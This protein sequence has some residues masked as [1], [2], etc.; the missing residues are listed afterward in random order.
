[1]APPSRKKPVAAVTHDWSHMSALELG[2]LFED[3]VADPRDVT[4]VFLAHAEENDPDHRIYVRLTKERARAEAAA[5]A[6]RA[7]RGLRRGPLDGV[8]LSWKDNFDMAGEPTAAGSLPLKDR[9]PTHDAEVLTRLTQAGLVA[10][11]KTNMTELAFSG[12]GINPNFGTP[13]NPWDATVERAPGG[14]SA[15]AGVSVASGLAAAAIGTDTGGSVRIPS[16]WNGLVGLKTTHSRIPLRGTVPLSATFDTVGPFTRDVSDAAAL[17]ALLAD[18][19]TPDIEGHDLSRTVLWL[20]KGVAGDI[21]WQDLDDGIAAAVDA[22]LQRLVAKGVRIAEHDLPELDEINAL[23]WSPTESR[24]VADAYSLWGEMLRINEKDIYR[25]VFERVM[26]GEALKLPDI[27]RAD[28]KREDIRRRYLARTAG[29]DAVVMP[30]VAI[31]PPPIADL[32]P[33]GEA[34]GKANRRALR[35]TTMGNQLGVCAITLPVGHDAKGMP[36][37]LML[38]AAPGADEKLFRLARA[39]ETALH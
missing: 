27:M 36:V 11:G 21:G 13:A 19:K 17:F 25:P 32:E 18:V 12:L 5:A 2:A 6:D 26:A 8:P 29:V 24:L 39:I 7:K 15:G 31:T 10:L 1:M 20:P 22:A 37:G 28:A 14:S 23:A 30:T 9:T 3:R 33:G 4:E 35:N 16:A 38:Q 34:Y